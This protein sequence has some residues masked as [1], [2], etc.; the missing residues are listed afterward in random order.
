MNSIL[1]R[2]GVQ[3]NILDSSKVVGVP[4]NTGNRV[5]LYDADGAC[6]NTMSTVKKIDTALRRFHEDILMHMMLANCSTARVHL[7]PSGCFKNGRHLLKTVKPY[8]ANRNGKGKPPLLEVLR[9]SAFEYFKDHKEIEIIPNYDVEADDALMIDAFSM[10]NTCMIS[11]DKDLLI[12]PYESYNTETGK[13]E[14][15]IG[16]DKFGWIG[17]KRW[18]TSPGKPKS[19]VVGKGYKFFLAQMLMGDTAD[20]V[21]GII[22][23]N[24]K[25]CGATIAF[26]LLNPI[27]DADEAVN[28]VVEGYKEINQNI[29]AEGEAMWLLRNRDDNVYKF[30]TEHDLSPSNLQFVEDTFN[31]EWRTQ[32]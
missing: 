4:K 32:V 20:N 29:I 13:F 28:L 24:G 30:L 16:D 11:P 31:S 19:K 3:A 22:S 14:R 2:F 18:M 15:L 21:K 10:Q 6:Y 9:A 25:L 1:S 27:V 8:Q 12:N 23:Y 7:T 5:L 26:N 17:M